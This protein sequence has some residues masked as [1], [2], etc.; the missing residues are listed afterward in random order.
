MRGT[1]L[2]TSS[3]LA[4]ELSACRPFLKWVGGKRQLLGELLPRLPSKFNRYFEPFVGG[5]ALFFAA[6]PAR[7]FLSDTNA[8]LINA[9]TVVREAPDL[10]IRDL[11]RHVYE[12]DYFYDLR[13]ADRKVGFSRWSA[14]R[15]ASRL[16]YLNRTCFNGLYRV[17]SQGFFNAPFGRY[18]N[19][20]IVDAEN[21]RACSQALNGV[22]IDLRDFTE[23]C[24]MA[25]RGDF[26]YLDPPYIPLSRTAA[27][28]SYGKLG[29]DISMQASL[30][31]ICRMLDRRGVKFMLS[32]SSAPE[33]FDLYRGFKID[34]VDATRALNSNPSRRGAIKEVVVTNY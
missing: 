28:T 1:K 5:G 30:A 31:G 27:F 9:Y 16:I 11:K 10:L 3:A 23:T 13:G 18:V 2:R 34:L 25:R 22:S 20:R 7:A 6:Q 26:V 29:F 14:V 8:E 15:R 12:R 24:A 19:P 21:L 33:V 4:P 32:N 17:S